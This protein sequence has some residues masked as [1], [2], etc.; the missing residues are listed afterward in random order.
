MS[1]APRPSADY[2]CFPDIEVA[3]EW[4]GFIRGTTALDID[5]AFQRYA[6][7]DGKG[8]LSIR[9]VSDD[10]E[11]MQLPAMGSLSHFT[12]VA[13]SP[14]GRFLVQGCDSPESLDR[15]V[16]KLDELKPNVVLNCS[17]IYA[18]SPDSRQF[19][20]RAIST[21]RNNPVV[22]F[23][24]RQRHSAQHELA[25][26]CSHEIEWRSAARQQQMLLETIDAELP[27]PC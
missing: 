17:S 20:R 2:R 18:F 7:E 8:N 21:V 10:V 3:K 22:R 4:P 14:D 19:A 25:R 1:F 23:R 12:E 15:R 9:R 11:L 24:D 13:F 27:T 16:W 5:A 26:L 6:R